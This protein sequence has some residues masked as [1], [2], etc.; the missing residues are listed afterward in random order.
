MNEKEEKNVLTETLG[1]LRL[2]KKELERQIVA[3][4]EQSELQSSVNSQQQNELATKTEKCL[5]MESKIA[6]QEEQLEYIYSSSK[7]K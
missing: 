1:Q 4:K 3:L 2:S 6:L 5:S 7:G